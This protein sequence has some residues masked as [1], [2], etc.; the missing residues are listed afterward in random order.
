MNTCKEAQHQ[1]GIC[2]PAWRVLCL[3][4]THGLSY[5]SRNS[6]LAVDWEI[7][8][9]WFFH[10]SL[11]TLHSFSIHWQISWDSNKFWTVLAQPYL[12]SEPTTPSHPFFPRLPGLHPHLTFHLWT[13][14]PG[15]SL[16][17]SWP[18]FALGLGGTTFPQLQ[19]TTLVFPHWIF[20]L[21]CL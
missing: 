10:P 9:I 7:S 13:R 6:L 11:P 18:L 20:P 2:R 4:R 14:C 19:L 12:S 5:L 17:S 1:K 15:W 3:P 8:V 16:C 21:E